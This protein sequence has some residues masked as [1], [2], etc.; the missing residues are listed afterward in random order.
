MLTSAAAAARQQV[1]QEALQLLEMS[2]ITLEEEAQLKLP[3]HGYMLLQEHV[4][5]ITLSDP[6]SGSHALQGAQL[7]F[8]QV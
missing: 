7:C 1:Q 5:S 3:Q 4:H 6:Q 8:W 2:A